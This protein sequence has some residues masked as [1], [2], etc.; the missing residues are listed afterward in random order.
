MEKKKIGLLFG[1]FNPIHNGHIKIAEE[2]IS[3]GLVDEVRLVVAQQNPF[4][5]EYDLDYAERLFLVK[6]VETYE[7]LN[8]NLKIYSENIEYSLKGEEC[9]TYNVL[10]LL[11]EKYN[12]SNLFII[13]G[14]DVYEAITTWYKGEEILKE[15]NF[16]VFSR[17][18]YE[19]ETKK[20][21]NCQYIKID[22]INHIS[23]SI[24]RKKI[25]NNEEVNELIP[26][27]VE[28]IIKKYNLY[29]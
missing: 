16:I 24:I 2:C 9:R 29:K 26:F 13:C 6:K 27:Y 28:N 12:D 1:S 10:K 4:K 14:D 21:K 20:S 7:L 15:N 18:G 5:K 19:I 3:N 11:K 25:K 23:S 8:N 22:G 17:D